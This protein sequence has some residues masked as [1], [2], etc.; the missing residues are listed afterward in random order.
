MN[1]KQIPAGALRMVTGRVDLQSAAALAAGSKNSD[2]VPVRIRAR[3]GQPIDHWFWGRIVHDMAGFK[4][5]RPKLP[6]DYCHNDAEVL[7]FLAEFKPSNAGLDVA[8]EL[9]VFR[10]GDRASEILHKAAA[11]VPYQASIYFDPATMVLEEVAAGVKAAVNGY[12]LAGPATIV[13]KWELR[14]VAVCP[15]GYDAQTETKLSAGGQLASVRVMTA[16][17][18]AAQAQLTRLRL[19]GLTEGQA[20][21]AVALK[22]PGKR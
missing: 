20:R 19:A 22:L 17:E 3:S 2:R 18:I 13:R 11:G 21:Y 10:D 8:G 16:A 12:Q 15:Y 5:A 4:T 1:T 14:G 7:G 6:I 9:I